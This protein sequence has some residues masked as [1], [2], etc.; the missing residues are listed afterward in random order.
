MSYKITGDP[1]T[2]QPDVKGGWG[3]LPDQLTEDI[4]SKLYERGLPILKLGSNIILQITH[5][6]SEWK[7]SQIDNCTVPSQQWRFNALD[8]DGT[9]IPLRVDTSLASAANGSQVR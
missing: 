5:A 3:I 7:S 2:F 1:I 4:G 8:K 6:E 9:S